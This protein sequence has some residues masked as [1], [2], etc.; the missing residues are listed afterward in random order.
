MSTV[1]CRIVLDFEDPAKNFL[2]KIQGT[3]SGYTR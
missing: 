1:N 2:G 3:S